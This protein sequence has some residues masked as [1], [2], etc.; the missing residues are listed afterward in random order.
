MSS[1][2]QHLY[3]SLLVLLLCVSASMRV[4]LAWVAT[5]AAPRKGT[6]APTKSTTIKTAKFFKTTQKVLAE[7]ATQAVAQVVASGTALPTPAS[8]TTTTTPLSTMRELP[9]M[10][11]DGPDSEESNNFFLD[12]W[13]W[14]LSFFEEHLTNLRVRNIEEHHGD[15]E[16]VHELYYATLDDGK[17]KGKSSQKREKVYTISLES[18]EYRDIRMT[19]MHCSSMQTFRCLSYPRNGDIPVMGMSMIRMGGARNL[20]IMDYQPLPPSD[21]TESKINDAYVSALIQLRHEI[22]S[23][24]SG[25]THK[26][27]A[28]SE[29]RTY[30][31]EFPLLG[32][33]NDAEATDV[34]RADYRNSVVN[35]QHR[36]VAKHTELTQAFG[37]SSEPSKRS[38]EYVLE[39]HSDFDTTISVQEPSK[40]VL[41]GIF[42]PEKGDKIFYNVIFPLSKHGQNGAS[43][44]EESS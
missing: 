12:H 20:A 25:Y 40:H 22:P 5:P 19:Y 43:S 24:S 37:R 9:W 3:S 13:N 35:A 14:Q 33:C 7:E 44:S 42:G 6:N 27:F 2:Q 21:E 1:R 34:E 15:D 41:R 17:N 10:L 23:M 31:T 11:E 39:R 36:Y 32:R 26:S 16:T 18:D 8:A 29:D 28:K 38:D 30:F 4:S